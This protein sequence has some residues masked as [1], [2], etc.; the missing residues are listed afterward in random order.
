MERLQI[1]RPDGWPEELTKVLAETAP[2]PIDNKVP[3][4][5]A[6]L[7]KFTITGWHCTRL[8]DKEVE[9]IRTQGLQPPSAEALEKRLRE[10][11]AEGILS[12][13][14]REQLLAENCAKE[15]NRAGKIWFC[16]Y[17]P[18]NT[19][20]DGIGRFFSYW[21]GEALYRL[22]ERNTTTG[23]VLVQIGKPRVIEVG[24][25]V[26]TIDQSCRCTLHIMERWQNKEKRALRAG[27]AFDGYA[28]SP[29][30]R[31]RV[32]KIMTYPE[33]DFCDITGCKDWTRYKLSNTEES[34]KK[35]NHAKPP[36]YDR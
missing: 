13:E 14:V 2:P 8:T 19:D 29:I 4:I 10:I 20:E 21:G 22:H 33:R 25:P 23:S 11:A 24:L 1:D 16:F 32:S 26:T 3:I 27:E 6:A 34:H 18:Y 28:T 12:E 36:G 30:G 15:A 9:Q 17:E 7:K 5:Q 35:R 31:N